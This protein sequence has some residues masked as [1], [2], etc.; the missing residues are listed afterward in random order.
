MRKRLRI[1]AVFVLAAAIGGLA[2]W[3]LRAPREP[4]YQGK[5][6]SEWLKDAND[7]NG[8]TP[9]PDAVNA[10]KAI[11]TNA[12]PFLIQMLQYKD[13]PLKFKLMKLADKQDFVNFD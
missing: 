11:G 3:T 4:V 12:V 6:L 7:I 9:V 10:I 2:R 13:S 5:R 8:E 1:A